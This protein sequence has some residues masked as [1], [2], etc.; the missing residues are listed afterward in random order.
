MKRILPFAIA[1]L[2]LIAACAP[3]QQAS[4]PVSVVQR[5]CELINDK[6]LDAYMDLVAEDAVFIDPTGRYAGK[7]AI[8]DHTQQV[9][10]DADMTCEN[11]NLQSDGGKVAY[12]YKLFRGGGVFAEGDDGFTVV[13]DGKIAFEGSPGFWTLECNKDPSQSFC[14]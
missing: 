9:M 3:T 4:D 2:F 5:G 6:N 7:D 12:S 1:F 8:R 10:I 13:E 11:T 14:E